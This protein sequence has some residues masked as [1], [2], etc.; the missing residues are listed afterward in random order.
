M[1]TVFV[2]SRQVIGGA[3]TTNQT[4]TSI[5]TYIKQ[6]RRELRDIP[7]DRREEIIAGIE[8][9]FQA[10]TQT[11]GLSSTEALTKLGDPAEIANVALSSTTDADRK[12]QTSVRRSRGRKRAFLAIAIAASLGVAVLVFNLMFALKTV[13]SSSM[14]PTLHSNQHV[15]VIK[16][17]NARRGQVVAIQPVAS[18]SDDSFTLS[19]D[20]NDTF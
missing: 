1:A 10:M 16:T 19:P 9:H 18:T 3:M 4:S 17:S 8:D 5:E 20:N 11:Q 6:L 7:I 2:G 14:A 12:E 15:L 13:P